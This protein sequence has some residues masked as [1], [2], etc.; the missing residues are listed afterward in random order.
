MPRKSLEPVRPNTALDHALEALAKRDPA[1]ALRYAIPALSDRETAASAMDFVARALLTIGEN[2][3]A[4]EALERAVPMLAQHALAPHAVAAAITLSE[5]SGDV[6]AL[7]ALAGVFGADA[8]SKSTTM[9][10]SLKN[11]DVAAIPDTVN[12]AQLVERARLAIG[13]IEATEMPVGGPKLALWSALPEE[14]FVGLARTMK[15]Q[16][17]SE[18]SA[19]VREGEAGKSLYVLARGEV[20]VARGEGDLREE[21][22]VLGAGTIFG[23]MALVSDAP[24]VASVFAAHAVMVLEASRESID[25]AASED[26]AVGEHVA[27]FFHRRL[28][29]N[30][31]RTSPLLSALPEAERNGLATLFETRRTERGMVLIREGEPTPALFLL[32]AGTLSVHRTEAGETLRLAQLEP[33]TCVGEIGL[34]LRRPATASVVAEDSGVVLALASERFLEVVR[35]RPTLLARLYELAVHREDETRSVL[36]VPAEDIAEL[37]F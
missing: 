1:R 33:G 6:A 32:E 4:R 15:V 19:V 2:S 5:L 37:L 11:E 7:R 28:V 12:K 17:L 34:V 35:E 20:R 21:L 3:L 27:E 10:P 24:R 26:G 16:I 25:Q 13:Q 18:N 9:I 8:P 30:A 23:E 14:S 22:A 36:A 29:D 31:L